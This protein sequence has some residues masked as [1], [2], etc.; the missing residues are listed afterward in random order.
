MVAFTQAITSYLSFLKLPE[1]VLLFCEVPYILWY[2]LTLQGPC[3]QTLK[4][5]KSSLI[6]VISLNV[7]PCLT[8][9]AC[10]SS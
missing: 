3:L 5:I 9:H 1:I 6:L 7:F 2:N 10:S 4:K 8:Q